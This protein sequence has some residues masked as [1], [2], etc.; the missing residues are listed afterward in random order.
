MRRIIVK[1][2]GQSFQDYDR[3]LLTLGLAMVKLLLRESIVMTRAQMIS[4]YNTPTTN[5]FKLGRNA[6][7]RKSVKNLRCFT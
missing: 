3:R 7:S 6:R 5:F 1:R 2:H 4:M